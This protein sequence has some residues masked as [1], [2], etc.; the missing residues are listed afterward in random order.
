MK[1]AYV[2]CYAG[3]NDFLPPERRGKAMACSFEVSGSVKDMIESL[4]VPHTEVDVIV[5]NGESV[6]FQY[7]PRDEDYISVYPA[8]ES[9][10]VQSLKHLKPQAPTEKRFILDTHLGRLAAYLRM[11]GFDTKYNRDFPDEELAESSAQEGRILLTRDQG[12]LKRNLVKYG[13]WVRTTLPREQVVEVVNY[14]DLIPLMIPFRRCVHCNDLLQTVSKEQILHRL[15]PE[16]R[17]YHN[18]FYIC[19][20]C[21]RIYW[22]GSHYQRMSNFIETIRRGGTERPH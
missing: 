22:K 12:L 14:F 9:I 18:E 8:F 5:V 19:L 21:N 17:Q 6:D 2:R 15:L 16:T 13:Y 20:A 1:Q 7:R 4:G 10:P 11:L 3:L